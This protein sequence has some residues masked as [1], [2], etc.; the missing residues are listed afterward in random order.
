MWIDYFVGGDVLREFLAY[1]FVQL[2]PFVAVAWAEHV[3]I[4]FGNDIAF[5]HVVQGGDA[6]FELDSRGFHAFVDIDVLGAQPSFTNA[7]VSHHA[8]DAV[9]AQGTSLV[10]AFRPTVDGNVLF[11]DLGAHAHSH[12]R[13]RNADGVV[14]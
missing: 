11:D 2:A 9:R 7:D 1:D 5:F 8:V 12:Y 10:G 4:G 14:G 3:E 13:C 6:A